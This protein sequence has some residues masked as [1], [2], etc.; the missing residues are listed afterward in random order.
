MII[1]IDVGISVEPKNILN[2]LN[3]VHFLNLVIDRVL[4]S[5]HKLFIY[6]CTPK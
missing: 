6:L 3:R 2:F 5:T 1:I 4:C